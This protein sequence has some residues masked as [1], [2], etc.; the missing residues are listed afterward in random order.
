MKLY[1]EPAAITCRPILMLL[2]EHDLDIQMEPLSLH[3][4]DHLAD[5]YVALNPHRTVPLLVDGDFKL[6]QSSAILKFLADKAGSPLY[7]TDL[8]QRAQVNAAMD[9]LVA[10]LYPHFGQSFIYP[11]I[12][13][14]YRRPTPE[15]QASALAWGLERVRERLALLETHMLGPDRD[16]LC[17]DAVSIADYLGASI[18]T[19]GEWVGFDY[20]PYPNVRRWLEA[21]CTRP[22][23]AQINAAFA[24]MSAALR[25]QRAA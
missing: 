5:A 22:G 11:Q 17:G 25:S 9:W 13:P 2:T 21:V 15:A 12:L 7:P 1:Y 20:S 19:A 23:W 3:N 14:N 16:Y 6:T 4:G 18:V 8:A 10:D 24:G